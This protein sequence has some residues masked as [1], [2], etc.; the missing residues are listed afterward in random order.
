MF[1]LKLQIKTH[2]QV[3][4]RKKHNQ[5]NEIESSGKSEIWPGRRRVSTFQVEGLKAEGKH[6]GI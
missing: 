6:A 4:K 5:E 2:I 1:F 3:K